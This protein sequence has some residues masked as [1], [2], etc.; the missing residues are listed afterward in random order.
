MT[1]T[2][3][4]KAAIWWR[5]STKAQLEL[6]P[7][8]QIKESRAKLEAEGY[9]VPDDR[10]IGA[11][12]HSL[13][14]L[15]CP[16]MQTLLS[17]MR[18]REVQAV[19]MINS[20]RLSGEMAQK[21]AIID[22]AKKHGVT[23]IAV[24]SPIGSGPEGEL[25]ETVRTYAKYLQVIRAQ[26]GARD[27]LRDRVLVKGLPATGQAPYG[28]R[29][30]RR[31]DSQGTKTQDC[32]RLAPDDNWYI[33]QEI[34]RLALDGGSLRSI[35]MTLRDRGIKT[36]RGLP[37]WRTKAVAD[38]LHNP[39]YAGRYY[40]MR[41]TYSRPAEGAGANRYRRTS[42]KRRPID[43]WV[44]LPNVAV[45]K[46]IVSWE[47]FLRMQ[48]RLLMNKKMSIRNAKL[49]YLL[50]GLMRCEVHNRT[51]C[52]RRQDGHHL[53][54]CRG[55]NGGGELTSERCPRPSLGGQ[56]LESKVWA[57]AVELLASPET[58]LAE[59]ERRRQAQQE[60]EEGL[61][62]ALTAV[63]KRLRSLDEQEME[64]S[65][66]WLQVGLSEST[67]RRQLALMK[68]ERTWCTDEQDRIRQQIDQVRERFA[69][70][71]QVKALCERIGHRLET[72]TDEDRRFVLEALET[73]ITVATDGTVRIAFAVPMPSERTVA[74]LPE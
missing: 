45:E 57:R 65:S 1:T 66:K 58:V 26:E 46:A 3:K 54:R 7:E 56:G 35:I 17:W 48:E 74:T 22:I 16:E 43:E 73:K 27:G 25:I 63:Q 51:Y 37:T 8:T 55:S 9:V 42:D 59:A 39:V 19:G 24:Q 12:W 60:T 18:Q 49:P 10:I 33:V 38:I 32:S 47:E 62:S 2:A 67:V 28:Y 52:G 44:Q 21:L 40:A 53:Y 5:E 29:F 71:E 14:T 30:P 34:W 13:D 36:A 15:E 70:V 68:A 11:V 20:D 41:K 50:R 6:S 64:L 4:P 69:T 23:L 31:V 72:A 61:L